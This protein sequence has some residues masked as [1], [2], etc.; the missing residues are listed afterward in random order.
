MT[1]HRNLDLSPT[2]HLEFLGE[3][4]GDNDG[5]RG[6]ERG[7]EHTHVADVNGDV[8]KVHH[9]IEEGRRHHETWRNGEDMMNTCLR[10]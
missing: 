9:M 2:T 3:V 10:V 5:E 1:R 4:V 6:E 8:Q 7:Q